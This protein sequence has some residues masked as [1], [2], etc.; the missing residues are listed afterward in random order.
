MPLVS[1]IIPNY[2]HGKFLKERIDSVLNQSFT[3]FELI[4]LD[5]CSRDNSREIIEQFRTQTKLSHIIYNDKNSGSPFKQ[6]MKGIALA[7]GEW[8]WIAESDDVA[9]PNFL[10]TLLR[11]SQEYSSAGMLYSNSYKDANPDTSQ[12]ATTADETNSDFNSNLWSSNHLLKGGEANA[13]YLCRKNIILNASSTLIKKKYL[14]QLPAEMKKMKYYGDWY[15][16]ICL[17]T[18]TDFFYCSEPLNTFRRHPSSL[19]YKSSRHNIKPDCFRILNLLLVQPNVNQSETITYFTNAY[20][21]SGLKENTGLSFIKTMVQYL[22][23]NPLLA[24][25]VVSKIFQSKL[26]KKS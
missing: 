8:I 1:V 26:A 5:D 9:N 2:N 18:V 21:S 7:K 14:L 6:W 23:I 13:L 4:I 20:L 16:Y 25:K 11:Y 22:F 12:F 24:A 3:D 19:I 17:A 10:E 15:C